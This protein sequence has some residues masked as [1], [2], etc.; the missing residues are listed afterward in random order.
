MALAIIRALDSAGA[1]EDPD[2][3]YGNIYKVADRLRSLAV[4]IREAAFGRDRAWLRIHRAELVRDAQLLAG[5]IRDIA[6][7]A[8]ELTAGKRN[9][10]VK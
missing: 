6:P 5:L 10:G 9:G 2:R 4:S 1:V 7:L 8:G 3:I